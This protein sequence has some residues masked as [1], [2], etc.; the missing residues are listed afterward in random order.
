MQNNVLKKSGYAV[1]F[2]HGQNAHCG[3]F[4]LPLLDLVSENTD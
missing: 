3:I 1:I 4:S 2:P